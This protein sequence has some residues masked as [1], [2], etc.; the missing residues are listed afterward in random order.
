MKIKSLLFTGL[1]LASNTFADSTK[2]SNFEKMYGTTP[3]VSINSIEDVVNLLETWKGNYSL[4]SGSKSCK[5]N[6]KFWYDDVAAYHGMSISANDGYGKNKDVY[7]VDDMTSVLTVDQ[8]LKYFQSGNDITSFEEEVHIGNGPIDSTDSTMTTK[9][10]VLHQIKTFNENMIEMK[11]KNKYNSISFQ[12]KKE[13][14]KLLLSIKDRSF[15]LKRLKGL[16]NRDKIE[17]KTCT[18]K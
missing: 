3:T 2:Q 9:Y 17:S 5:D 7:D 14:G 6:L 1:L 4:E 13:D 12:L 18:F 10:P 16:I 11:M 8:L 15:I